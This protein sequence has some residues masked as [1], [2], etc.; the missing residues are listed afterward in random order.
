MLLRNGHGPLSTPLKEAAKCHDLKQLTCGTT[1]FST[2]LL[3][4]PSGGCKSN[5]SGHLPWEGVLISHLCC[6]LRSQSVTP[7]SWPWA[8]PATSLQSWPSHS[9]TRRQNGG[10]YD[11][12]FLFSFIQMIQNWLNSRGRC[13]EVHT[14]WFF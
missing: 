7:G 9:P 3:T 10:S 5:A 1:D 13:Q 11:Q 4:G 6:D 8:S 2:S 14:S 12:H